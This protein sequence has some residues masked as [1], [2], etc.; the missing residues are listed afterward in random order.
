[1]VKTRA[2]GILWSLSGAVL[3]LQGLLVPMIESTDGGDKVVLESEH[4]A[5]TCATGHDHSICVQAG[6]N[7]AVAAAAVRH[8]LPSLA[9]TFAAPSAPTHLP[10]VGTKR[11][12]S[13]RA[14]PT[15]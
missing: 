1:M 2:S 5:A 13:P 11:G 15:A 10:S 14:P 6:S 3:L 12:N 9:V 8:H 7:R 4:S